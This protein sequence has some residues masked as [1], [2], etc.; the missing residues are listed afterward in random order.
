MRLAPSAEQSIKFPSLTERRIL[1][2][3]TPL[4]SVAIV[5]YNGKSLVE[6]CVKSVLDSDFPLLETIVIDNASTDGSTQC[7][8]RLGDDIGRLNVITNRINY[9]FAVPNN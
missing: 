9:S 4:V 5:T 6:K 8:Q 2:F 7:V 1:R 3:D